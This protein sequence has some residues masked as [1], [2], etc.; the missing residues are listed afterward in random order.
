MAAFAK[1]EIGEFSAE[2]AVRAREIAK[3]EASPAM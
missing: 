2:G 1:K 3:N